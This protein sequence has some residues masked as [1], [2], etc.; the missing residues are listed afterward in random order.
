MP[1]SVWRCELHYGVDINSAT[2]SVVHLS[3][4]Y[5]QCVSLPDPRGF[6]VLQGL[7]CSNERQI[8]SLQ[9]WQL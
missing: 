4:G 2:P 9:L 5:R 3:Q 6:S 1:V 8:D 7:G